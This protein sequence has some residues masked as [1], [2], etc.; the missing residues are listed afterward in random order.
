[1]RLESPVLKSNSGRV[2]EG[3]V[4]ILKHLP[5]RST[6]LRAEIDRLAD[7]TAGSAGE[8]PDGRPEAAREDAGIE[9]SYLRVRVGRTRGGALGHDFPLGVVNHGLEVALVPQVHSLREAP[10]NVLGPTDPLSCLR[11]SCDKHQGSLRVAEALANAS[12]FGHKDDQKPPSHFTG[13][14]PTQ[15]R[16]TPGVA[17][18]CRGNRERLGIRP[19]G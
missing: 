19:Q 13:R 11:H 1:M 5:N 10:A 17:P 12:E 9:G 3:R 6:H 4:K 2:A 8:S 7:P 14:C 18:S 16:R 15:L